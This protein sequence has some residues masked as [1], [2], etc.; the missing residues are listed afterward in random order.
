MNNEQNNNSL[1]SGVSFVPPASSDNNGLNNN[2]GNSVPGANLIPVGGGV[3][4]ATSMGETTGSNVTFAESVVNNGELLSVNANSVI[5]GVNDVGESVSSISA[6]V[7]S[8]NSI[9]SSA[10]LNVGSASTFDIGISNANSVVASNMS[11]NQT[12]S[13][14][15]VSSG[16]MA[17]NLNSIPSAGIASVSDNTNSTP[18]TSAISNNQDSSDNVVSVGSYLGHII[19][20]SI[21]VV[22]FIMLLVKAF[23]SKTNKNISNFAKAQ[24]ILAVIITVLTVVVT[25]VFGAALFAMFDNSSDQISDYDYGYSYDYDY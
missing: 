1:N 2:G 10:S 18:L 3:S 11:S 23:S 5:P 6:P 13:I 9:D 15:N 24:L 21:P 4:G 14:N 16:V 7:V 25:I 19:L 22:G 20:F 17:N 12:D 8:G